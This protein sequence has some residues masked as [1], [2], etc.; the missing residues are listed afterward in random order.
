[1]MFSPT[2]WTVDWIGCGSKCSQL[3]WIGLDWILKNGPTDISECNKVDSR[4][5]DH[6]PSLTME[7]CIIATGNSACCYIGFHG[8]TDCSVTGGGCRRSNHQDIVCV[9]VCRRSSK[10]SQLCDERQT[11]RQPLIYART[12]AE[13]HVCKTKNE[14]FDM[15]RSVWCVCDYGCLWTTLQWCRLTGVLHGCVVITRL[16]DRLTDHMDWSTCCDISITCMPTSLWSTVFDLNNTTFSPKF[17][18]VSVFLVRQEV[19]VSR[20]DVTRRDNKSVYFWSVDH[21]SSRAG[22]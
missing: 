16:T 19:W 2:E 14:S 22:L 15:S 5:A 20:A 3:W 6:C 13:L 11:M 9:C 12:A 7:P 21:G 17:T 1:M 18:R 4:A 8:L 10:N